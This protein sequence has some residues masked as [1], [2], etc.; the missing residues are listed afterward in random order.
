[1]TVKEKCRRLIESGGKPAE[2]ARK[3]G[4]PSR[5]V[6]LWKL[7]G[8]WGKIETVLPGQTV[9]GNETLKTPSPAWMQ[10]VNYDSS[11]LVDQ[12]GRAVCDPE[13]IR[14][15]V[16]VHWHPRDFVKQCKHC[17]GWLNQRKGA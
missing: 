12:N 9:P 17:Q 11:H 13:R 15:I 8:K 3:Y 6:R 5:L 4:V 1:M 14:G 10:G 2:A 16:G 7:R